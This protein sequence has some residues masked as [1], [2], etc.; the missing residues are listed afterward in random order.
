MQN[1]GSEFMW[2]TEYFIKLWPTAERRKTESPAANAAWLMLYFMRRVRNSPSFRGYVNQQY[3]ISTHPAMNIQANYICS[4][5]NV[6]KC[7]SSWCRLSAAGKRRVYAML[8]SFCLLFWL[9]LNWPNSRFD[10]L[11]AN[12]YK[13]ININN[14]SAG[15]MDGLSPGMRFR[16]PSS[17]WWLPA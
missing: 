15:K 11:P 2:Q 7:D 5:K 6:N 3:R 12:V 14:V 1:F 16:D 17:C 9:Q 4:P 13:S 8:I 10:W